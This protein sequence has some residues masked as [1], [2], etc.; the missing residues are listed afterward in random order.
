VIVNRQR[1]FTKGK[2]F[3]TKVTVFYD[4]ITGSMDK[5]RKA[6]VTYLDFSKAFNTGYS[7]LY[8]QIGKIKSG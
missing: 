7:N 4:E 5:G 1:G 6:A 8:S 2:A 3:L